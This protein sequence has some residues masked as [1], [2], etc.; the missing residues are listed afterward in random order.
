M[1]SGSEMTDLH[2]LASDIRKFGQEGNE[3]DRLLAHRAMGFTCMIQG[4]LAIAHE[5]FDSF[6]KL[7]DYEKYAKSVSFQFSSLNDVSSSALAMATTCLLLKLPDAAS[8]WRD[9]ALAWAL[10]SHNHVAICQ[11]LVFS[12]GFIGGLNRR[13]DEMAQH[14]TQAH[15]YVTKH[16]LTLW[17]PY[18]ELSM[19]LSQLLSQNK[20]E[21]LKKY[22]DQASASMETILSQNGPYVTVWTVMYARACLAHGH[23]E[24]GASALTRIA[25]R[26]NTGEKWMESEYLRLFAHF[27]YAQSMIDTSSLLQAL[28]NAM[29][30]A[31][32]QSALLFVDDIQQ[33]IDHAELTI[34]SMLKAK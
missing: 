21:N 10:R 5:E 30:L 18:I 34:T 26:I 12:G 1:Q 28:R 27:Q 3:A 19:A 15:H 4:K 7:F 13:A 23:F 24:I 31:Q 25:S 29:A 6:L 8:H 11:S 33:D 9:K 20:T 32:S 22:F 17:T 2:A 14:M 16:Q